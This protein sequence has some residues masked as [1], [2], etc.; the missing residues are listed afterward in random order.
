MDCSKTGKLIA[1]L[2]KENKFTQQNLA[3]A[4]GISNKTVSK[5]ECGLGFPDASLW[6]DLS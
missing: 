6:A 4:L 2:R 5:W 3:D 1:Q